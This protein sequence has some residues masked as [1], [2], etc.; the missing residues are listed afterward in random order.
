MIRLTEEMKSNGDRTNHLSFLRLEYCFSLL[1]LLFTPLRCLL[2]QYLAARRLD[3][4]AGERQFYHRGQQQQD[5]DDC[6]PA[7]LFLL[8]CFSFFDILTS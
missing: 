6:S 1:F 8:S 3:S 7:L 4:G 2:L 5:E